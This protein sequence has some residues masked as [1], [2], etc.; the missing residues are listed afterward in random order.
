MFAAGELCARP[1][2]W[3]VFWFQP[4]RFT[5]ERNRCAIP[6]TAD[7]NRS[8][9]L[10]GLQRCLHR[11]DSCLKKGW[12][13]SR[14]FRLFMRSAIGDVQ[15]FGPQF[16]K[17]YN[18]LLAIEERLEKTTF[19]LAVVGAPESGKS[20]LVNALI[21]ES[22]LPTAMDSIVGRSIVVKYGDHAQAGIW[23]EENPRQAYPG[24]P[25]QDFFGFLFALSWNEDSFQPGRQAMRIEIM[26]PAP[27][28]Q[29]GIVLIRVPGIISEMDNWAGTID[30]PT[31]WN[32]V[33]F[34]TSADRP[35]V[36][37]EI[38]LLKEIQATDTPVFFL[39]NKVDT[40]SEHAEETTTDF[41]KK[42]I[43]A[44]FT[45]SEHF[46]IFS[47]SALKG[48]GAKLLGDSSLLSASGLEEFESFLT[49]YLLTTRTSL[50]HESASKE[51]V[52]IIQ[53][54]LIQV[55]LTAQSLQLPLDLLQSRLHDLETE[56]Q[57]IE[58]QRVL[59]KDALE[60]DSKRISRILEREC[61]FLRR[62]SLAHLTAVAD[63]QLLQTGHLG[64]LEQKASGRPGHGGRQILW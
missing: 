43:Q 60:E 17:E 1:A 31:D 57:N 58:R 45:A 7:K 56:F 51:F 11:K 9:L 16:S 42:A 40:L 27:I 33:L 39:L 32:A 52:D 19:R 8:L 34:V 64:D 24:I 53:G 28:L 12:E 38:H 3:W 46:P 14:Q 6:S 54:I 29:Q 48:L 25:I 15:S 10:W 49:R 23:S 5:G 21:G 62:T 44:K 2:A 18:R 22:I 47:I 35:P 59:L 30:T 63:E 41:L 50:V 26:H 61:H 4:Y 37:S 20:T 36:E 55:R 13:D